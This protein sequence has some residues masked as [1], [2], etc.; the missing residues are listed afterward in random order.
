VPVWRTGRRVGSAFVAAVLVVAALALAV[1]IALVVI[2]GPLVFAILPL[3]IGG[4]VIAFLEI[5]R[6]RQAA[7]GMRKFR[8][9]AQTQQT[10][11]TARDRE[12][13]A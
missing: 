13:Q 7:Q 3:L 9:E 10:D 1:A 4:A 2:G 12:T 11:F 8:E 6:R 5:A